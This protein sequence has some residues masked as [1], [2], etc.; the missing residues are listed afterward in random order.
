MREVVIR[1]LLTQI[2]Q[3]QSKGKKIAI[4]FVEYAWLTK[5]F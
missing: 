5:E 2:K 4:I 3:K 1:A